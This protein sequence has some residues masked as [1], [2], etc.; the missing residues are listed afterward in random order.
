MG[1]EVAYITHEACLQHLAGSGHPERPERLR[2]FAAGVKASGVE[3][4]S[5]AAL[6]AERKW[7]ESVHDPIYLDS[8][9][10]FSEMGGGII[11]S[12]TWVDSSTWVAAL[13]AAGAGATAIAEGADVSFIGVRPPGHHAIR[14][15][16]MGFC[17]LN[18][19]A[20]TAAQLRDQGSKVAIIDWDVHHGNG[21]QEMV[22]ADA[23][24]LYVS[25]HQAPF[26]PLTGQIE[27]TGTAGTVINLPLPAGTGGDVYRQAFERIV[28][29]ALAQFEPEVLLVSS[30]FDAHIADPLADM[31][32][33][34]PDY[35]FMAQALRQA[36][37]AAPILV[38]LE[39]GYDLEAIETSTIEV[40][41]GLGDAY[42]ASASTAVSPTTAWAVLDRSAEVL[43]PHWRL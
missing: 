38:F 40:V 23:G 4:K 42:S 43:S 9:Q 13:A 33:T 6:P 28:T 37:P 25:L 19:V 11:D 17:F 21:T 26:Y 3:V 24:T 18:N 5:I 15:R 12:D 27:E 41:R 35:G 31:A 16:A 36:A 14:G 10:A 39:G 7:I 2:A 8:L 20:I 34:A 22:E 1:V 32:L 30:G 29:P